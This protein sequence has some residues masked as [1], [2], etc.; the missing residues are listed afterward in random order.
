MDI[1]VESMLSCELNRY[2][3]VKKLRSKIF[4]A[5][6]EEK[7]ERLTSDVKKEGTVSVHAV[8]EGKTALMLSLFPGC[9]STHRP[10]SVRLSSVKLIAFQDT[11]P[12]FATKVFLMIS[13]Y[14]T[15]I[16]SEIIKSPR[17]REIGLLPWQQQ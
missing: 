13:R 14:L 3:H 16:G 1:A 7:V 2:P 15:S 4:E 5:C 11:S 9:S 12:V 8:N 17:L 10:K 6:V